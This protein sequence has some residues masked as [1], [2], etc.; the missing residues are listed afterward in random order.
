MPCSDTENQA[1]NKRAASLELRA[2]NSRKPA[3]GRASKEIVNKSARGL[4]FARSFFPSSPPQSHG[5]LS[6]TLKSIYERRSLS[7]CHCQQLLASTHLKFLLSLVFYFL[8]SNV[9]PLY[10]TLSPSLHAHTHIHARLLSFSLAYCR[11]KTRGAPRRANPIA[12]EN[13]PIAAR[14]SERASETIRNPVPG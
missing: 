1:K 11:I 14:T 4:A 7:F 13:Q 10:S 6:S 5:L 9:S 12:S 8:F 2:E 3:R